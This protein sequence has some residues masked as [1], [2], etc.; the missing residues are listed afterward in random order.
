MGKAS[1]SKKIRRV[2]QA[3]VSRAPGQRRNLAYPALIVG[4]IVVGTLLVFL[5]RDSRQATASEAPTTRDHWHEALGINICG[6]FLG[7]PSD[8]GPDR[9]GIHTHADGLIHIHPFGSGATGDN[10]TMQVFLDQIGASV[11]D[12][13]LTLKDGT[14]KT[15]GDKCDGKAGEVALF[16]WSPTTR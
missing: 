15:N 7:N 13:S 5:A 14:T 16:V 12:D 1:S 10:A 9:T 8:D 11:T 2:Q 4:I 6:E 3:G